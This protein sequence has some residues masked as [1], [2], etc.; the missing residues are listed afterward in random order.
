MKNIV[1][2]T[3]WDDGN[4]CDFRVRDLLNKYNLKGTFY[5]SKTIEHWITP[6]KKLQ[7]LSGEEIK[8]ISKE[9]EIGAH[10]L[11]HQKHMNLNDEE[12]DKEIAGSKIYLTNLLGKP[13]EMFSY[14]NGFFNESIVAAVKRAGFIGA[15]TCEYF[16]FDVQNPFL[17]GITVH[18]YPFPFRRDVFGRL[19]FFP[20]LK[21]YKNILKLHLSLDSFFGWT[22]LAKNL[23]DHALKN[24]RMFHLWGHSWEVEKYYMWDDL[25]EVFKYISRRP[26]VDYLT[27]AE[28][29]KKC[30]F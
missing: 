3:S 5:I 21:N 17:M 27:N 15:R 6:Q 7:C 9:H 4:D 30:G 18:C 22:H 8:N 13:V 23:F 14:P 16:Q 19:F 24:G 1:V 11:S 12:L 10:T 25:E 2:T 28:T 20:L 29:I 26:N